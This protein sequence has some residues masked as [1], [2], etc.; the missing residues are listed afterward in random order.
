M[1]ETFKDVLKNKDLVPVV[2]IVMNDNKDFV[3]KQ[4]IQGFPELRKYTKTGFKSY[5]GPRTPE[6]IAE[7][8][9]A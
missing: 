4:G 8:L 3:M 9:K 5:D 6:K 1:K 7:F 2:E